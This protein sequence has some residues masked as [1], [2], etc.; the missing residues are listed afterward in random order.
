MVVLSLVAASAELC[1][2]CGRVD[3]VGLLIVN[4]CRSSKVLRSSVFRAHVREPMA[5]DD[6]RRRARYLLHY[7]AVNKTIANA[8]KIMACRQRAGFS[9]QIDAS[10]GEEAVFAPI[11]TASDASRELVDDEGEEQQLGVDA[12]TA[13]RG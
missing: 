5:K 2:A 8:Q 12:S 9:R 11:D 6:L 1:A 3:A 10:A 4:S 7:T 13:P